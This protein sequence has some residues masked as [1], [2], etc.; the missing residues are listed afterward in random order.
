MG[1][2]L[3]KL[4]FPSNTNLTLGCEIEIQVVDPWSGDLTP[5]GPQILRRIQKQ[6]ST[7]RVKSELFQSMLEIDTPICENAQQ[8]GRELRQSL[9]VVREAAAKEEVEVLMSGTHPFAN[10]SE[11]LLTPSS[12][13]YN[14]VDKNQWI[15]RRLQIFGLHVHLGMRD[16][17][18]AIAMNNALCHYLPLLLAI[19]ASSP[20]WHG[21]DTGLASCRITFFEATPT[22][23]H[24][25]LSESWADFEDLVK[26]LIFSKSISSMKDLWWDIRPN[27]D[28]GT[29]EVRIADCPPTIREVEAIVALLHALTM[30]IDKELIEGRKF[31]APPDWI[32]REN[33]WRAS[34]FGVESELITSPQGHLTRCASLWHETKALI[35]NQIKVNDYHDEFKFLDQILERGPSYLRQKRHFNGDFKA[36]IDHL[37]RENKTDHP[38]W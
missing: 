31:S 16:G 7:C 5:K 32:L 37:V 10:Y 26:R 14:L 22:G 3:S 6:T 21:E 24:P 33:K 25:C 11:R 4:N 27:I 1:G 13:Y 38:E 17:E 30:F 15:T 23:G 35:H 28:F 12:R 29:I 2:M 19:S 36:V 18:H 8:V 9:M 34:R 20:F